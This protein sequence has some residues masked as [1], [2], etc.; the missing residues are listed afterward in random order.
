M[1]SFADSKVA[2]ALRIRA[3]TERESL[4]PLESYSSFNISLLVN[5]S[6]LV[7]WMSL[8]KRTSGRRA[9]WFVLAGL[10]ES[11]YF[12]IIV[13]LGMLP[14]FDFAGGTKG[15]GAWGRP[16]GDAASP[17]AHSH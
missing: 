11:C 15:H 16:I 4:W 8:V 10:L 3:H 2:E 12:R 5:L 13:C 7:R 14:C 17:Q 6:L 9:D 1:K